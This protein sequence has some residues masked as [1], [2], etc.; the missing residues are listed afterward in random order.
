MMG[1]IIKKYYNN[2]LDNIGD[3]DSFVWYGMYFE[4]HDGNTSTWNHS[5]PR[6]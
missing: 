4:N 5:D 6:L 2:T 3:P 1:D